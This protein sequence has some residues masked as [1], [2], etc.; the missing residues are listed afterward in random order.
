M[1]SFAT[2]AQF[3]CSA[4]SLPSAK[5]RLSSN[6]NA[7]AQNARPTTRVR[8]VLI[9][10]A[11]VRRDVTS[12]A[13]PSSGT[14]SVSLTNPLYSRDFARLRVAADRVALTLSRRSPY[15]KN[16]VERWAAR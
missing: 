15:G 2:G 13:E 3:S 5:N 1:F 6:Q 4:L 9:A 10:E 12:F 16:D 7:T 11:L 8:C 14:F